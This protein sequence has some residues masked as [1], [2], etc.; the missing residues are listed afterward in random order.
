M[1]KEIEFLASVSSFKCDIKKKVLRTPSQVMEALD[2]LHDQA[3]FLGNEALS[4]EWR[5]HYRKLS[6]VRHTSKKKNAMRWARVRFSPHLSVSVEE[7]EILAKEVRR[8]SKCDSSDSSSQSDDSSDDEK[9]L[10][11]EIQSLRRERDRLMG[12]PPQRFRCELRMCHYCKMVGHLQR[13]CKKNKAAE[14]N[15]AGRK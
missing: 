7:T 4:S 6:T 5:D 14:G 13:N 10:R 12:Q 2:G 1:A 11:R 8:Y 3:D 15:D 9:S